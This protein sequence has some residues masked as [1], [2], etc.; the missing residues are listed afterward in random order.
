MKPS[1]LSSLPIL[2]VIMLSTVLLNGCAIHKSVPPALY[3]LGSLPTA[4]PSPSPSIPPIGIG[5]VQ[6]PAWLDNPFM[7]YRLNYVDAQQPRPYANSQWSMTPA[8]LI[9]Q[10][11]KGQLAQSGGV[12]LSSTESMA[13]P[14]ILRL[15]LDDFIQQFDQPQQ[16]F[17][18]IRMLA[19]LFN[20][21]RLLAQKTFIQKMPAPS[22]DAAGGAKAFAGAS[23]A[24][25]N[26]MVRWLA[27]NAVVE[28]QSR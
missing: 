23:D 22:P 20:G 14:L 10:R 11:L 18:E 12:V 5:A 26:D 3:D 28:D 25:I 1:R 4:T 16:S 21:H 2:I 8:Q 27:A 6:A 17:V 9:T 7:F 13:S 15:N 19:S 24:L